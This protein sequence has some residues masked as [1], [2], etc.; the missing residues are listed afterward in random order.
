[1]TSNCKNKSKY[2]ARHNELVDRYGIFVSQLLTVDIIKTLPPL[3][4]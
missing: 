4:L 3:N 2:A 1:M